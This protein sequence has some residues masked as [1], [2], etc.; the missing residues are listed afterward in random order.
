MVNCS[1]VSDFILDVTANIIPVNFIIR[2][3]NIVRDLIKPRLNLIG[4]AI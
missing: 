1:W 3:L 2:R 4:V